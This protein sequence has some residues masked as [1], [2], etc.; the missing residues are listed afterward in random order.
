M[1]EEMTRLARQSSTEQLLQMLQEVPEDW[2]EAALAAARAELRGRGVTWEEKP[3]EAPRSVPLGSKIAYLLLGLVVAVVLFVLVFEFHVN[4]R[5]LLLVAALS[6]L[7]GF[8]V[9]RRFGR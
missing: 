6:G 5:W 2:N 9:P 3:E 8:T 4:P 1:S 7:L